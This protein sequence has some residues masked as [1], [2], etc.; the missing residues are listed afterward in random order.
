[1]S[2]RDVIAAEFGRMHQSVCYP[3]ASDGEK[4]WAGDSILAALT[5]AGYR[6]VPPGGLDAETVTRGIEAMLDPMPKD[7]LRIAL[8]SRGRPWTSDGFKTTWGKT[9]AKLGIEGVTFHDLRGTFISARAAEGSSVDDIARISGH[10]AS[11]VKTVLERHYLA[12]DQNASDAV[13]VRMD[14]TQRQRKR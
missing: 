14:R 10:S 5:A 6:I 8:N 13:I 9:L 7:T 1:M 3:T 12:T 2:A 4:E 11:E